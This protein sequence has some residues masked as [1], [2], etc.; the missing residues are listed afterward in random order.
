MGE[1][2]KV[3]PAWGKVFVL[4]AGLALFGCEQADEEAEAPEENTSA[5]EES[6]ETTPVA[7]VETIELAEEAV[8][9]A[10]MVS[11]VSAYGRN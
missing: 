9:D 7:V 1:L 6:E 8:E 2:R 4:G 5:L 3:L 10:T 11:P